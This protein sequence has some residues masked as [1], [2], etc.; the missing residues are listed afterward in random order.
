[1]GIFAFLSPLIATYIVIRLVVRSS[2]SWVFI[3]VNGIIVSSIFFILTDLLPLGSYMGEVYILSAYSVIFVP[4]TFI[5]LRRRRVHRGISGRWNVWEAYS[6]HKFIYTSS[7]L[8]YIYG[9]FFI[10]SFGFNISASLNNM[11]FYVFTG[12][13]TLYYMILGFG[14]A[15]VGMEQKKKRLKDMEKTQIN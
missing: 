6:H 15:K 13:L 8:F 10:W 14:I 9:I 5:I 11:M 1:M 12:I 4:L 3:I 2:Y 7:L